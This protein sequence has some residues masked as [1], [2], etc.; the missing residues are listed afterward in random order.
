METKDTELAL[1]ERI[2]QH[3]QTGGRLTQRDLAEASGLSLG[4][5]NALLRRLVDSG[6]V[7]LT[8]LTSKTVRYGLT[9][10]GVAEVTRRAAGYFRDASESALLYRD[11]IDALVARAVD[12][13]YEM[14]VLAG[15][16]EIDSLLDASCERQGIALIKSADPERA[17]RLARDGRALV[18]WAETLDRKAEGGAEVSL[19][20]IVIRGA[21]SGGAVRTE[22]P[23]SPI[24]GAD[25]GKVKEQA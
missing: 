16:S 12:S 18:V 19:R 15:V 14:L 7:L 25:S 5:T 22:R 13:G 24:E 21:E 6:W 17:A 2:Y 20:D 4:M 23:A 8:K 11:R 10:A 3:Q 9:E 1:L